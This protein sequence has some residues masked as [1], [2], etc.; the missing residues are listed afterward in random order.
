[1]QS[2][3]ER[4]SGLGASL[5]QSWNNSSLFLNKDD[6]FKNLSQRKGNLLTSRQKTK[7]PPQGAAGDD[8]G[9]KAGETP[10]AAASMPQPA[11]LRISHELGL[12][13]SQDM[14]FRHSGQT[15]T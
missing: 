11:R 7:R 4:D 13:P 8:D 10:G 5:Q 3:S 15:V 14:L 1:M 9:W 6:S 2:S 12:P